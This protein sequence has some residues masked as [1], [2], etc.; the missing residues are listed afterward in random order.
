M[1]TCRWECVNTIH[2]STRSLLKS[3]PICFENKRYNK[4]YHPD[5]IALSIFDSNGMIMMEIENHG[6]R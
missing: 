1:W 3:N 6:L 2:A 5:I 4:F